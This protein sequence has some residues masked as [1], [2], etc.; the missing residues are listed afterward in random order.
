MADLVDA[1][2]G[3]VAACMAAVGATSNGIIALIGG[4]TGKFYV[5]WPDKQTLDADLKAGVVHVSV[6][7]LP[8]ERITSITQ[9]D[10]DWVDEDAASASRETRRQ[11]KQFQITIWASTPSARDTLGRALDA[12]M[13]DTFRLTL[14]D[15]SQAILGYRGARLTDDRQTANLYR[16]DSIAEVNFATVQTMVATPITEIDTNLI[17]QINGADIATV[18][19]ITT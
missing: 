8:A 3:L 11:T 7:P 17:V 9:N 14:A 10:A 16:R 19:I 12:A 4:A 15:G 2:A 6:W 5:G 18:P 1:A 13:S